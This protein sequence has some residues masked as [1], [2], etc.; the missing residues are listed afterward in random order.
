MEENAFTMLTSEFKLW[1]VKLT[2]RVADNNHIE[3]SWQASPDKEVRRYFIAST[4]S[5]WRGKLNAR[6]HIRRVFKAD[7]L[8]LK[9]QCAK[10]KPV[11]H[12]ALEIAQPVERDADQIRMLRG[13]VADLTELVL[14][15]ASMF[16]KMRDERTAPVVEQPV[17]IMQPPE[18]KVSVRS[19]KTIDYVSE[20]WS[21]AAAIARDMGLPPNITYRKLYYLLRQDLVE[22]SNG[23]WR[24]KPPTKPSPKLNGKHKRGLLHA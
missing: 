20:S 19:I 17:V 9:Q 16:S 2:S 13:E 10:P 6:A 7:G 8:T 14:E 4:P 3:L 11:L 18:P 23:S 1:G 12:K 21:S 22:Q 5:D 15:M 24:K